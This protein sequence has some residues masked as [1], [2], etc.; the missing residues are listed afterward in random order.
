LTFTDLETRLLP[1]PLTISGITLGIA[2]AF[3]VPIND[4]AAVALGF[5]GRTGSVLDSLIGALIPAGTLWLA[6]WIFEKVRHKQGL[7]FGDV[8]M[9]SEAGAFLG[10]R[11]AFLTLVSASVAGSVVGLIYILVNRKDPQNYELPLGS[12]LGIAGI[13]VAAFG[14]TFTN[15]YAGFFQ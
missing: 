9:I 7:G 13:L 1:E 15:W 6:G 12:F 14:E 5:T 8:V 11:G 4:G 10:L 3:F 2:F